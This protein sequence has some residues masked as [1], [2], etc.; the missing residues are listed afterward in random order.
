MDNAVKESADERRRRCKCLK[1]PLAGH[2]APVKHQ[3]PLAIQTAQRKRNVIANPLK[4]LLRLIQ[5]LAHTFN[6]GLVLRPP[7][8]D[9]CIGTDSISD[10]ARPLDISSS[11]AEFRRE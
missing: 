7:A 6:C 3:I 5:Q 10:Y 4:S 1:P 2:T 9:R 8:H 11:G